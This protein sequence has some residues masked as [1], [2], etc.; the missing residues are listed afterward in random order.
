MSQERWR[1]LEVA[2]RPGIQVAA[3]VFEIF[4]HEA[5]QNFLMHVTGILMHVSCGLSKAVNF[6]DGPAPMGLK[7]LQVR[8][9]QLVYHPQLTLLNNI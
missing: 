3:H 9:D 8:R 1:L 4:L 2:R 6:L 5:P 7:D